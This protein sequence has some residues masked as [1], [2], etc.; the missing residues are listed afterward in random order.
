MNQFKTL[1]IKEYRTHK[2]FFWLPLIILCIIYTCAG[3]LYL[4]H[5]YNNPGEYLVMDFSLDVNIPADLQDLNIFMNI[6]NL[7]YFISLLSVVLV[8]A[9]VLLTYA[10]LTS[11]MVN[12]DIKHKCVLFHSSM[13]VSFRKRLKAKIALIL[14]TVPIQLL[15]LALINLFMMFVFFSNNV[16]FA[17]VYQIMIGITQSIII[18]WIMMTLYLSTIWLFA[19]TYKNKTEMN[20]IGTIWIC[21]FIGVLMTQVF[22]L[23]F[24]WNPIKDFIFYLFRFRLFTY[25]CHCSNFDLQK[26]IA[27]NWEYIFSIQTLVRLLFTVLFYAIGTY[28]LSK[29]EVV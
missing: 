28:I 6:G 11:S 27:T 2:M 24:I 7:A 16:G 18:L 3:L 4:V 10:G 26:L 23:A 19:A 9:F 12:N 15:T 5:L 8:G 22:N 21:S 25:G 1:L 29:R 20:M 13:P 17:Q 14:G